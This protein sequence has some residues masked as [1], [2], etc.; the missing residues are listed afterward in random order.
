MVK[1]PELQVD[2]RFIKP[3]PRPRS[4]TT[5]ESSEGWDLIVDDEKRTGK[6]QNLK[7][8][9]LLLLSKKIRICLLMMGKLGNKVLRFKLDLL[10]MKHF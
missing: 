5:N 2:S 10:I 9:R 4:C 8:W 6:T 1:W 3:S 7:N